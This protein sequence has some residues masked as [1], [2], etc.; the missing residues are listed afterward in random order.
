MVM[1]VVE[2]KNELLG[3]RWRRGGGEGSGEGEVGEEEGRGGTRWGR[4]RKVR[5]GEEEG[6]WG[7]E[8]GG[9]E[10]RT[11][12]FVNIKNIL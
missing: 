6:R 7:R 9:G 1:G 10:S 3:G 11:V 12:N 4:R 5:D 2:W 8:E